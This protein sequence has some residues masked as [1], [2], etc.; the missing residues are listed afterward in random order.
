MREPAPKANRSSCW[1]IAS[2]SFEPQVSNTKTWVR[3]AVVW[4]GNGIFQSKIWTYMHKIEKIKNTW[5][6]IKKYEKNIKRQI[7][8]NLTKSENIS[9]NLKKISKNLKMSLMLFFKRGFARLGSVLHIFLDHRKSQKISKYLKI[10][11]ICWKKRKK[12]ETN[13]I[14]LTQPYNNFAEASGRIAAQLSAVIIFPC[15]VKCW[16]SMM[17]GFKTHLLVTWCIAMYCLVT[18]GRSQSK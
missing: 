4:I 5:K 1:G 11:Q 7:S 3:S 12:Q 14:K 10:S 2:R 9:K 17:K 16:A 13:K 6:K 8:K 18:T 15:V